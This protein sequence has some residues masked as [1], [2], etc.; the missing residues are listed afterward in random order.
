MLYWWNCSRHLIKLSLEFSNK[1]CNKKQIFNVYTGKNIYN[2]NFIMKLIN[3][4]FVLIQF[5]ICVPFLS[6]K[7][8]MF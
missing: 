3:V 2:V 5:L 7:S 1:N 6:L 4:E 8:L